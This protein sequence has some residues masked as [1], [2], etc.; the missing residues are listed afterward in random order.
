MLRWILVAAGALVLLAVAC[1]AVLSW[2][3]DLPR[4]QAY[5]S[6]AATQALGRPVRFAALRVSA[7]PWPALRF[8]QLEVAEDPRF[9]PGPLLAVP[10]GRIGIRLWPLLGLRV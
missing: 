7:F 9:G 5:A 2:L 4:V 8:R 1:L 6:Q 10:E 3:V